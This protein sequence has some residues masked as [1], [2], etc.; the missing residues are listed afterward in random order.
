LISDNKV[1]SARADAVPSNPSP[2][3]RTAVERITP[4][5]SPRKFDLSNF[6]AMPDPLFVLPRF[7]AAKA[8]S[9]KAH[10]Y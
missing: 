7:E 2:P 1:V 6:D 8:Q 4:A 5:D 9:P 3:V 10:C